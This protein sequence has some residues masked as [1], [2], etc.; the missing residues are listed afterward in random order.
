MRRIILPVTLGA[1]HGVSDCSAGL[2]LG[3]LTNSISI[4]G[5]GSMVLLYNVLAFGAQPL[6]GLLTDKLKNPK[7]AV[8]SGLFLM[9]GAVIVLS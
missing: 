8:L 1:A 7:L 5:V 3:S 9:S 4:Y 6:A 2:I